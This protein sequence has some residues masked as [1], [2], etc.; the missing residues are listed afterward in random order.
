M[1]R[2]WILLGKGGRRL[3]P[4]G[5][6]SVRRTGASQTF[7]IAAARAPSTHTQPSLP[8]GPYAAEVADQ[9]GPPAL[10]METVEPVFG[11]FKQ[12][13]GFRQFW[14]GGLDKVNG[15]WSL[16]CAGHIL[17]KLFRFGRQADDHTS[18]MP[19]R[20]QLQSNVSAK[21]GT[22]LICR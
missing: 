8:Q 22:I 16:I 19:P 12:G 10:R 14:L 5:R 7:S 17:L 3:T 11:Q 20:C 21:Y 6:G 4:F 13:R 1:R 9:A 15:E 18:Q 2:R